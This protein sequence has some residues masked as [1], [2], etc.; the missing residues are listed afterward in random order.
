MIRS[1]DG[2]HV[3]PGWAIPIP[4]EEAEMLAARFFQNALFWYDGDRFFIVPVLASG[5][6]LPLPDGLRF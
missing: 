6:P 3:G 1:A 4:F 5:S 2:R